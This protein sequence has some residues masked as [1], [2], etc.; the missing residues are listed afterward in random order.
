MQN[1]NLSRNII[2]WLLFG[3]NAVISHFK[4]LPL[5]PKKGKYRKS[6]LLTNLKR[7]IMIKKFLFSLVVVLTTFLFATSANAREIAFT[8]GLS[9][10][11]LAC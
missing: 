6:V 10:F 2:L 7:I 9:N 5:Q 4:I 1:I 11:A 8:K 3:G